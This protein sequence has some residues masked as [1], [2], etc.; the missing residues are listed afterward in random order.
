[1]RVG[2][3]VPDVIPHSFQEGGTH[4][5]RS[6]LLRGSG[7]GRLASEDAGAF[8]RVRVTGRKVADGLRGPFTCYL[9][10]RSSRSR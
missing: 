9:L 10:S 3:E 2:S 8:A 6:A 5:P 1:M 4:P 7:T